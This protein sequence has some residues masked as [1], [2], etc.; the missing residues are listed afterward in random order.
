MFYAPSQIILP[1]GR[2]DFK[3][4]TY[5]NY[6]YVKLAYF[7]ITSCRWGFSAWIGDTHLFVYKANSLLEILQQNIFLFPIVHE[8]LPTAASNPADL[9]TSEDTRPQ[10]K[11]FRARFGWQSGR[12][13]IFRDTLVLHTRH[14]Q[15]RR[16]FP[17]F[18]MFS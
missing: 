9:T 18:K 6:N 4:A 14:R 8:G 1:A 11:E 17:N 15:E 16:W 13:S 5:P 10:D 2:L 12:V 3:V 7:I